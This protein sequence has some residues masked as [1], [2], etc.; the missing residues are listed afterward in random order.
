M[1]ALAR[2]SRM[3]RQSVD[4][5]LHPT[6]RAFN[7]Y[8]ARALDSDTLLYVTVGVVL[9]GLVNN[10]VVGSVDIIGLAYAVVNQL[11]QFYLFAGL[12]YFVGRQ[13][14]GM[15]SFPTV[16]YTFVLFYVPIAVL[17]AALIWALI[18]LPISLPSL[19]PLSWLQL[20]R[21][22]ELAALAFYAYQA[23]QAALYIRR[24]R[25]AALTVLIGLAALW[26]IQLIFRQSTM[27]AF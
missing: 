7:Y 23:V 3:L 11:F 27:S 24:P 4:V 21:L 14:G 20:I 22:V 17:A 2:L 25:D 8:G 6:V 15:G 9:I 13:F 19:G 1:N 16:A 26:L 10:L 18:L 5:M 12:T